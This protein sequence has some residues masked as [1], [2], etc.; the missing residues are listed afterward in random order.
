MKKICS[1]CK[2]EKDVTEF[3]RNKQG[4]NG[5]YSYC[6]SCLNLK[7]AAPERQ[8][9]M[10]VYN[11]EYNSR[12]EVKAAKRIYIERN[13][14]KTKNYNKIRNNTDEAKLKARKGHYLKKYNFTIEQFDILLAYQDN[15]CAICKTDK[16]G[17]IGTWHIDHDHLLLRTEIVWQ[18]YS[19]AALLQMQSS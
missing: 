2:I 6:K 3:H 5:F 14:V 7:N 8:A 18:V 11:K 15:K 17:G 13:K 16:P 10:K 9:Y 12:P 1:K 19:W 4:K